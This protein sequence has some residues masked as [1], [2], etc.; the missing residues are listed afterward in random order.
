LSIFLFLDFAYRLG[1][2][3]LKKLINEKNL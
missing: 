1:N 2:L 3:A